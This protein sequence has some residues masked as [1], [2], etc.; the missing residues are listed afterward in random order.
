MLTD[1]VLTDLVNTGRK[2]IVLFGIE[3]HV[4]VLQTSLDLMEKG[5][6]EIST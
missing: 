1:E 4:C 2:Q 5:K 3:A 6:V